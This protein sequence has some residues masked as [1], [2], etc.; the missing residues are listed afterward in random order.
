MDNEYCEHFDL[1]PHILSYLS[2]EFILI[3]NIINN[4]DIVVK[5]NHDINRDEWFKRRRLFLGL[6]AE[7][8]YL[9]NDLHRPL[10]GYEKVIESNS[11]QI[12]NIFFVHRNEIL[13]YLVI[14]GKKCLHP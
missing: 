11:I 10:K 2:D 7:G 12:Q 9:N 13:G 5:T 4:V 6:E 8:D 14:K 3:L 1:F